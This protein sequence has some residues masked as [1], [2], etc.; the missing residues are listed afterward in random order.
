VSGFGR[1]PPEFL[2]EPWSACYIGASQTDINGVIT[3]TWQVF[4]YPMAAR[5][6]AE[7]AFEPSRFLRRRQNFAELPRAVLDQNGL[8]VLRT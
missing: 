5:N 2:P 6:V 4:Y 3:L 1:E 8:N 7:S